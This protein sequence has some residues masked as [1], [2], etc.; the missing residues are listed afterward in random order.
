MTPE[1]IPT[2]AQLDHERL[3][4]ALLTAD[5]REEAA[6]AFTGRAA[7][8]VFRWVNVFGFVGLPLICLV[9]VGLINLRWP[10]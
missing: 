3:R 8:R 1:T 4:D 2:A 7:R 10:L 6:V 5:M 9:A